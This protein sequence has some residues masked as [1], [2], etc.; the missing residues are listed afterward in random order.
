MLEIN[1]EDSS[2]LERV[3]KIIET[4]ITRVAKV[5]SSSHANILMI[6]FKDMSTHELVVD[7]FRDKDGYLR[8]VD[9]FLALFNQDHLGVFYKVHICLF[10]YYFRSIHSFINL[11]ICYLTFLKRKLFKDG[12]ALISAVR[13]STFSPALENFTELAAKHKDEV[14]KH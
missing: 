14:C 7:L 12:G 4:F 1:F 8:T 2:T 6:Y 10:V 11:Q 13:D 5:I 9:G 3:D